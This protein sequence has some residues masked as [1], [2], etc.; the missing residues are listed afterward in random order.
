MIS[1]LILDCGKN[2][3]LTNTLHKDIEGGE[4]RGSD[5]NNFKNDWKLSLMTKRTVYK[6]CSL[7]SKFISHGGMS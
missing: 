7:V 3:C 6:H 5:L 1:R 2:I 4:K